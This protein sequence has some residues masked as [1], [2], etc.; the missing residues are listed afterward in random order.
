VDIFI[1]EKLVKDEALANNTGGWSSKY[2]QWYQEAAL[3]LKQGKHTLKIFCRGLIPHIEKFIF[4]TGAWLELTE[5]K[6]SV[7]YFLAL[8]RSIFLIGL[9]ATLNKIIQ[10][11]KGRYLKDRYLEILSIY[12]GEHGYKG[13]FHVQIDLT[14]DCN[15][16]CIACWCNSPLFKSPRLSEREKKQHL[17]LGMVKEVIDEI[18]KMGATEVYYSGSGEPFMHPQIMEVLEYT[19]KKNLT[20]HVNTNFTLLDKEKIDCLIN[21]GVDFLT[22]STWAASPQAYVS[23]HPNRK[24]QDFLKIKENL[25]Y[26][27]RSKKDKP[28]IKLYNV[29]FNLNYFEVEQM[30]DFAKETCSE[31]V[32]F[33][34]VDTMPGVTDKLC[35]DAAQLKALRG[36]C[37]KIQSSLNKHNKVKGTDVLMFQF[38]QFLRRISVAEDAKEAKYDRNII[39]SMP[40]YIG[41]LF[42][43]IIP[44]GQVH[45]CLKA[46]RVP[47]GS[48]YSERF[49]E[50][51][52]SKKQAHFRQKTLCYEKKDP[53]FRLIGND[54]KIEEAGCYKS[55]DDI[56]RNSWMHNRIKIL[57]RPERLIFKATAKALRAARKLKSEFKPETSARRHKNPV[58]AGIIHGRK[59]FCGPEQVVIDPTNRCNLKCSSCWLYSPLLTTD[60]PEGRWLSQELSKYALINLVGEL[61]SLGTKQIRFTGGGEPFMHKDLM[62]A[63]EYA[64]IKGLAAAVTTNFGLVSKSDIKRL[65]ELGLEELCVSLW[66]SNSKVYKAVHPGVGSNYFEKVKE[67]LAYLK[68]IKKNKPRVT[69]AN[70]IVNDN[71]RDFKGMYECGKNFGADAVYFT[72]SDVFEG[73]T[74][75]L[76]LSQEQRKEL[77]ESAFQI[78]EQSLKDNFCLEFFDG[79]LR[80]ISQG[81]DVSK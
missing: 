4:A 49:S 81:K 53:F 75:K 30:V 65:V 16:N 36:S 73:Q 10:N 24:E 31:S 51:W 22:V 11:L 27:N 55:C 34:L 28:H 12:D 21:M 63:V 35:L 54:P 9:K 77:L 5:K 13:P 38:D 6:D 80:R 19:K 3:D 76:K 33:T 45:S 14:N 39:D 56:G 25:I 70:V 32:E 8:K 62:E 41:W 26:L 46:H 72:I 42:A 69:F 7:N 1:D 58:T 18:S 57:S 60:K 20:C 78:K 48:L 17:P 15:N 2:L 44:N 47:T 61:V 74:D 29:I 71:Y 68:E 23:T 50:I 43:R 59:A 67:N 52:N 37:V 79:F 40:C 64:C 66:A